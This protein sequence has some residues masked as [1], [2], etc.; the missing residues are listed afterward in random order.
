M[1]VSLNKYREKPKYRDGRE[2]DPNATSQEIEQIYLSNLGSN[3]LVR[4][5]HPLIA[6]API[7]TLRSQGD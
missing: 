2:V 5:S 3:L 7:M 6:V 4:A 1:A